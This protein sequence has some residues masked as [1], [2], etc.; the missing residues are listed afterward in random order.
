MINL[1]AAEK[2]KI[3]VLTYQQKQNNFSWIALSK[4][5]QKDLNRET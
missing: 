1:V 4:T 5:L 3:Y 2:R